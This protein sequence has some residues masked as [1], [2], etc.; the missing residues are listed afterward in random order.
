[1]QIE[2]PRYRAQVDAIGSGRRPRQQLRQ[3]VGAVGLCLVITVT[4]T[5]A[6]A[7]D[8]ATAGV[9]DAQSKVTNENP[10][11]FNAWVAEQ[12]R[13]APAK[14]RITVAL[15]IIMVGAG[16]TA[17]VLM[18]RR[19]AEADRMRGGAEVHWVRDRVGKTWS[20]WGD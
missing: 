8:T 10:P 1:M 2:W 14:R 3:L 7:V 16:A 17:S 6:M 13:N 9:V 20:Q 11:S 18:T 15:L 12:E 4:P 19:Q 5:V